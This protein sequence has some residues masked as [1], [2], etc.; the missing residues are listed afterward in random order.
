MNRRKLA[1]VN[2][3][4]YSHNKNGKDPKKNYCVDDNSF[5][6]GTEA[7]EFDVA[8]VA[9]NLKEDSRRKH[10]KKKLMPLPFPMV[11]AVAE[12]S[13]KQKDATGNYLRQPAFRGGQAT[14]VCWWRLPMTAANSKNDR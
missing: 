1:S 4:A 10:D 6:I 5:S 8:G 7:S 2:A 12:T 13:R 9:R 14:I 11:V 3:N